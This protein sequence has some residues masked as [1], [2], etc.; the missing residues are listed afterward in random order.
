MNHIQN[1]DIELMVWET[2]PEKRKKNN[3]PV[4]VNIVKER[5]LKVGDKILV[6]PNG[7]LLSIYTVV[8]FKTRR[9]STLSKYDYR[10][11][12]CSWVSGIA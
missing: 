3:F 11:L 4:N 12:V 6:Q 9:A 1:K 7:N 5:D 8:E 2:N 10:E